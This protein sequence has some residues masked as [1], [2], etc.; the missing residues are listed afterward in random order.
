MSKILTNHRMNSN[1]KSPVTW[2]QRA[3]HS[4]D[5]KQYSAISSCA[6]LGYGCL[7]HSVL[8]SLKN[9]YVS[10]ESIPCVLSL[11]SKKQTKIL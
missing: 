6:D 5:T 10:K 7:F 8:I 3:D 9:S 1:G 11:L 4:Q 2:S